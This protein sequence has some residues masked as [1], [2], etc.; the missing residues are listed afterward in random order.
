MGA[1]VHV[2]G[3]EQRI[4]SEMGEAAVG[5]RRGNSVPSGR[6]RSGADGA[7]SVGDVAWQVLR[8]LV[9][10]LQETRRTSRRM[11]AHRGASL[12]GRMVGA[13]DRRCR[14]LKPRLCLRPPQAGP[15]PAG[16]DRSEC[17]PRPRAGNPRR[18]IN[19]VA[20]GRI[21]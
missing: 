12:D 11:A 1:E 14:C 18:S 15:H 21:R 5:C 13:N 8:P 17:A 16:R 3:S 4:H 2:G 7:Q 6:C 19:V 20:C 10:S 9:W